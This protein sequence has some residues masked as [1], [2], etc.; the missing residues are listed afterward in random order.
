MAKEL[1][2]IDKEHSPDGITVVDKNDI[3]LKE[4]LVQDVSS[5]ETNAAPSV[6]A[7]KAVKDSSVQVEDIVNDR[8]TGGEDKVLAAEIGKDTCF[9]FNIDVPLRGAGGKTAATVNSAN[10]TEMA[11]SPANVYIHPDEIPE[12]VKQKI[13]KSDLVV[14][15][16]LFWGFARFSRLGLA[17]DTKV[18]S[19]TNAVINTSLPDTGNWEGWYMFDMLNYGTDRVKVKDKPNYYYIGLADGETLDTMPS[20]TDTITGGYS[21]SSLFVKKDEITKANPSPFGQPTCDGDQLKVGDIVSV[22]PATD[23]SKRFYTC[24]GIITRLVN[25]GYDTLN[26]GIMNISLPPSGNW[27]GYFQIQ[28][29]ASGFDRV[30]MIAKDAGN[31]VQ[32]YKT[33]LAVESKTFAT[34]PDARDVV[35]NGVASGVVYIH[36]DDLPDIASV[37]KEGD[38]LNCITSEADSTGKYLFN[39]NLKYYRQG[40]SSDKLGEAILNNSLPA[41]GSFE[42]WLRFYTLS[43]GYDRKNVLS[44][45]KYFEIDLRENTAFNATVPSKGPVNPSLAS[46]S[47]LH[48]P[49]DALPKNI[50]PGDEIYVVANMYGINGVRIFCHFDRICSSGEKNVNNGSGVPW[51]TKLP[52][53]AQDWTGWSILDVVGSSVDHSLSVNIGVDAACIYAA[54]QAEGSAVYLK[55]I[56]P[57]TASKK[58]SVVGNELEFL[59]YTPIGTKIRLKTVDSDDV[60]L[61]PEVILWARDTEAGTVTFLRTQSR[62]SLVRTTIAVPVNVDTG[63]MSHSWTCGNNT[64]GVK[65]TNKIMSEEAARAIAWCNEADTILIGNILFDDIIKRNGDAVKTDVDNS[66]YVVTYVTSLDE[67][68]MPFNNTAVGQNVFPGESV[69]RRFRRQYGIIAI[70]PAF[71]REKLA[72]KGITASSGQGTVTIQVFKGIAPS[73]LFIKSEFHIPSNAMCKMFGLPNAVGTVLYDGMTP[74]LGIVQNAAINY[75]DYNA[76]MGTPPG[77]CST[78]MLTISTTPGKQGFI[79]PDY[80]VFLSYVLTGGAT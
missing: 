79:V 76:A 4:E 40:T 69:N 75:Q 70:N 65:V 68:Q 25:D 61:C 31:K 2:L 35:N 16:S 9:I 7:V 72:E 57:N 60:N 29:L 1:T 5:G 34:L 23:A 63:K 74:H 55:D 64:S 17:S 13:R 19:T 21:L 8:T 15:S 73:D 39:M 14:F 36:P 43:T 22:N 66:D 3:V 42:G 33:R 50:Q 51:N 27:N 67:Q 38:L 49:T 58:I 52:A 62:I 6:A 26:Q 20:S 10:L 45:K 46:W 78:L 48:V 54:S 12:D 77:Y 56:P 28:L 41:E 24:V 32:H 44:C 11:L 30:A 37:I 71:I 47:T 18:N 59:L 53:D 80:P